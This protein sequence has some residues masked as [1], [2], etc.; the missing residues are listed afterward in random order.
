MNI[1]E[2]IRLLSCCDRFWLPQ[3]GST[4]SD[5]LCAFCS[6]LLFCQ[7]ISTFRSRILSDAVDRT[8]AT[9][10]DE[11]SV[12]VRYDLKHGDGNPLSSCSSCSCS[13]SSSS[14]SSSLFRFS[15]ARTGFRHQLLL[16]EF[17][18]APTLSNSNMY[19]CLFSSSSLVSVSYTHLTLPTIYSV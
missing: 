9:H 16:H 7:C 17:D 2:R 10:T 8:T 4:S 11:T 12:T 18:S 19:H 15:V 1:H 5:P 6:I 3:S 14:S 13:S